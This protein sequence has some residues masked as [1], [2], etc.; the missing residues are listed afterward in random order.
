M[1]LIGLGSNLP[2]HAGSSAETI[3][4][5][6]KALEENGIH[7]VSQS[8]YWKTAPVPVSSQPWFVNAVAAIETSLPPE[9]LLKQLHEI[10]YRFDRTRHKLNAARTLDLDILDYN[11]ICRDEAP[12]L[13]HPRL[14]KRAFVLL[15]L[16][17]IAP[18]WV[19]PRTEV[20]L[21]TLI[22]RLPSDQRAEAG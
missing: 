9:D 21:A 17:D 2:S 4:A 1:I 3:S 14:A 12:L 22:A 8:R 16:Q 13:P 15:P 5:A 6:L 7:V 10:E 20:A 11:G 19:H 18:D